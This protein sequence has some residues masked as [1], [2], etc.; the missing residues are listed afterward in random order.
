MLN[1]MDCQKE[2]RILEA[3]V[4]GFREHLKQLILEKISNNVASAG[5]MVQPHHLQEVEKNAYLQAYDEW[6]NITVA[7]YGK[8]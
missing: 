1:H 2:K 6:F 4:L 8:I 5:E 7:K 3:K